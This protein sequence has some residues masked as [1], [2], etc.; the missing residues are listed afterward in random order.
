MTAGL[1][2]CGG[3]RP[4]AAAG[5]RLLP[6]GLAN[7]TTGAVAATLRH[8]QLFIAVLAFALSAPVGGDVGP[9]V[10]AAQAG[11]LHPLFSGG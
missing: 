6:H 4:S 1:P 11:T 7:A 5:A 9:V 10:A 8:R 3:A 2:H